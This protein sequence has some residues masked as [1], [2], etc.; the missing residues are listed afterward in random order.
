MNLNEIEVNNYLRPFFARYEDSF[1]EAWVKIL[2]S[3]AQTLEE[4]APIVKRVRTKEINQDLN[5][6]YREVSLYRPIGKN[7]DERFTF[8]SVLETPG[9]EGS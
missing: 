4:I 3:E 6:E 1:Q 7:R 5:K 9:N 2:E 8:E